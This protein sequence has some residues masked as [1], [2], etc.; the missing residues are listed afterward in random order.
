MPSA[1]ASSTAASPVPASEKVPAKQN[2]SANASAMTV[3]KPLKGKAGLVPD[4]G[5][6]YTCVVDVQKSK[7]AAAYEPLQLVHT[8][9]SFAV[10]W[11]VFPYSVTHARVVN[12]RNWT[13]Q[14][15]LCATG[16][17]N[18]WNEWNQYFDGL[19]FALATSSPKMIGWNWASKVDNGTLSAA[20]NFEVNLGIVK[21]GGSDTVNSYGTHTGNPGANS[22]IGWPHGWNK[23]NGNRMNTY[24]VSAHTFYFQGT[25]YFEGNVGHALYEFVSGGSVGFGYGAAWSI[26]AQCH[27]MV[28]SCVNFV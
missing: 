23:Y 3:A 25:P 4:Q 21:I 12:R 11:L 6:G 27:R 26:M 2:A 16:G 9:R 7:T 18:T 17:G 24:Y 20:L 5:S 10:H 1:R 22:D 19:G 13:F 14:V 15:Q 28:G 8:A